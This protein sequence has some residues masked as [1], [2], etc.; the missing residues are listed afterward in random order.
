MG[1]Q[2]WINLEVIK[3]LIMKVA[4]Q[5]FGQLKRFLIR[6]FLIEFNFLLKFS[7][8]FFCLNTFEPVPYFLDF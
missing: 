1:I 7:L 5:I 3:L 2:G 4:L 6:Y 8:S